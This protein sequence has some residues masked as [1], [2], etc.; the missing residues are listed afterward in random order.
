M[1]CE[2]AVAYAP[3]WDHALRYWKVTL[4]SPDKILFLKYMEIKR[5]PKVNVNRRMAW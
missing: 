5:D 3:Y 4:E 2:G 1:F